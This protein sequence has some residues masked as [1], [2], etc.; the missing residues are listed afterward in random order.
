MDSRRKNGGDNKAARRFCTLQSSK[1]HFE[2]FTFIGHH[3]VNIYIYLYIAHCFWPCTLHL[4]QLSTDVHGI[5]IYIPQFSSIFI[6]FPSKW[7]WFFQA[8]LMRQHEATPIADN[9][10][11]LIACMSIHSMC[12]VMLLRGF[13]CTVACYFF[14]TTKWL[15]FS[16]QNGFLY[17]MAW[18][19]LYTQ[20]CICL[21]VLYCFVCLSCSIPVKNRSWNTV[22]SKGVGWGPTVN[23]REATKHGQLPNP[24][25]CV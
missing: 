14:C 7:G 10:R 24:K 3:W 15:F 9:Y 2:S 17:K 12:C 21:T 16:L 6:P 22:E 1:K 13:A 4:E 18:T 11:Y 20:R 23:N 25:Q 8:G 5:Y 19:C